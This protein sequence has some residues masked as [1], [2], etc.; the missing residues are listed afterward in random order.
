[1]HGNSACSDPRRAVRRPLAAHRKLITSTASCGCR[2]P[3]TSHTRCAFFRDAAPSGTHTSPGIAA[4]PRPRVHRLCDINRFYGAG[5]L[6]RQMPRRQ[7]HLPVPARPK[8]SHQ[9][10]ARPAFARDVLGQR[11]HIDVGVQPT[12]SRCG[13]YGSARAGCAGKRRQRGVITGA[14]GRARESSRPRGR[15]LSTAATRCSGV[16]TSSSSLPMATPAAPDDPCVEERFD[17]SSPAAAPRHRR[18]NSRSPCAACRTAGS[19]APSEP[20][21]WARSSES[22]PA[23]IE[24]PPRTPVL[25]GAP[26][27]LRPSRNRAC[28]SG[29]T[30]SR[31]HAAI[32]TGSGWRR[33]PRQNP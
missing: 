15:P 25:R 5:I 6:N 21:A 22:T 30:P 9:I 33:R 13:Q 29:E 10:R 19:P 23:R 12:A 31:R 3:G 17:G 7:R 18:W 27:R 20:N 14:A 32:F 26:R 16:V 28:R 8:F 4:A 2:L 11:Q 24:L 1:M